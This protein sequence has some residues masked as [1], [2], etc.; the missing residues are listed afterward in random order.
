MG[1]I[2]GCRRAAHGIACLNRPDDEFVVIFTAERGQVGVVVREGQGLDLPLVEHELVDDVPGFQVPDDD[3]GGEPHMGDLARCQHLARVR[4]RHTADGA[5]VPVLLQ[6]SLR[7][8]QKVLDDDIGAQRVDEVLVVFVQQ[9]AFVDVAGEPDH[10]FQRQRRHYSTRPGL[11][12]VTG[13]AYPNAILLRHD[14]QMEKIW[15]EGGSVRERS[16][17][18]ATADR[19]GEAANDAGPRCLWFTFLVYQMRFSALSSLDI[20]CDIASIAGLQSRI[21]ILERYTVTTSVQT[22]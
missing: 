18:N 22:E 3:D 5:V 21:N 14:G 11:R 7:A 15:G 1:G 17:R 8:P 16:E 20:R 19:Q 6:E 10:R 2:V 9:Q 4:H 13:N 12:S